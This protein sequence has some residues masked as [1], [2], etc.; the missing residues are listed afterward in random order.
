MSNPYDYN[1]ETPLP[2]QALDA[3]AGK[4]AKVYQ[5]VQTNTDPRRKEHESQLPPNGG[6]TVTPDVVEELNKAL[7]HLQQVVLKLRGGV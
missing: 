2:R 5:D 4:V 3:R 1:K 7:Y 6:V